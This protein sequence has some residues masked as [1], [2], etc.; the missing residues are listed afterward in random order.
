MAAEKSA[1]LDWT[2]MGKTTGLMKTHVDANLRDSR[3][4][5]AA[6]R[7]MSIMASR[8]QVDGGR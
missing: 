1:R 3:P 4:R 5:L 7:A 6:G 2:S 8:T